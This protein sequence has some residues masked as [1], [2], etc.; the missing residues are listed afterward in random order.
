MYVSTARLSATLSTGIPGNEKKQPQVQSL[1]ILWIKGTSSG[2]CWQKISRKVPELCRRNIFLWDLLRTFRKLVTL[3]TPSSSR[4]KSQGWSG[5]QLF[6]P[7]KAIP[8]LP[9]R[10]LFYWLLHSGIRLQAVY[11][12]LTFHSSQQLL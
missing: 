8:V 7:T 3:K 10:T 1:S 11:A 4:Q 6:I 12:A 2:K 9:V 5:I